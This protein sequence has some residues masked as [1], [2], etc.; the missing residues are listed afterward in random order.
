MLTELAQGISSLSM[1]TGWVSQRGKEVAVSDGFRGMTDRQLVQLVERRHAD[2]PQRIPRKLITALLNSGLV[3]QNSTSKNVF[4]V[5]LFGG[6]IVVYDADT[7]IPIRKIPMLT[8]EDI[9]WQM[10]WSPCGTKIARR[11]MNSGDIEVWD[12]TSFDDPVIIR[13]TM[14]TGAGGEIVFTPDG[15]WLIAYNRT[16]ALVF[17]R[18]DDYSRIYYAPANESKWIEKI[19]VSPD[20]QRLVTAHEKGVVR[21][22]S[23]DSQVCSSTIPRACSGN[24]TALVI[25]PDNDR[26]IIGTDGGEIH[27]YHMSGAGQNVFSK[28]VC[29]GKVCKLMF[30][31][32][33]D[34]HHTN[35]HL[36][37]TT[38]QF[39]YI[40]EIDKLTVFDLLTLQFDEP[41]CGWV[42]HDINRKF[43]LLVG[44]NQKLRFIRSSRWVG[45]FDPGKVEE[46]HVC[47]TDG[48]HIKV[49]AAK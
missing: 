3:I 32:H 36:I 12:L 31:L 49:L 28:S 30:C 39:S 15:K 35:S 45:G 48:E 47:P 10:A 22:W 37:I 16:D 9:A 1:A 5:L 33:E 27:S 24:I 44:T 38:S 2:H 34:G 21:F 8:S 11:L 19:A 42:D 13:A 25:S 23:I 29:E 4:A 20:S 7:C 46:A 17:V 26:L 18:T 43:V 40:F 6:D 41:E 14:C